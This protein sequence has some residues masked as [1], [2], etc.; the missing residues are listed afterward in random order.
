MTEDEKKRFINDII[1]DFKKEV[2]KD[3]EKIPKEWKG[4][5]LRQYLADRF[6]GKLLQFKMN[7]SELKKYKEDLSNSLL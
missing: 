3:I 2:D 1:L 6:T 7:R 4:K 5:E